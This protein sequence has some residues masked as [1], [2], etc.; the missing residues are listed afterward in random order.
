MCMHEEER[1]REE[2]ERRKDVEIIL[3]CESATPDSTCGLAGSKVT[4]DL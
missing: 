3:G 1:S 4:R 2:G